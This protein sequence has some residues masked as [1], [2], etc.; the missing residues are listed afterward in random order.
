M[1]AP[2]HHPGASIGTL[3]AAI[4]GAFSLLR[5][6]VSRREQNADDPAPAPINGQRA[7]ILDR[8]SRAEE[9]NRQN[10]AG[11]ERLER[12]LLDLR[13]DVAVEMDERFRRLER[14]IAESLKHC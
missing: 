9:Y 2:E 10:E 1:A 3:L 12:L 13:H 5:S 11:I 14:L 4:A 8:L 7:A 6:L